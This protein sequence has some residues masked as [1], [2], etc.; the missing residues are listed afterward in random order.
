LTFSIIAVGDQKNFFFNSHYFLNIVVKFYTIQ[1]L[2]NWFARSLKT[3]NLEN[4][5]QFSGQICPYH[6]EG[7]IK[8]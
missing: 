7:V 8:V 3:A 5:C 6:V 1:A 4:A 2:R